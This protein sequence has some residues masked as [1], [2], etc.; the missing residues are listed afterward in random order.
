MSYKETIP[1][2]FDYLQ[3]EEYEVTLSAGT[4]NVFYGLLARE[5]SYEKDGCDTPDCK[6][7]VFSNI[8]REKDG[9]EILGRIVLN[10]TKIRSLKKCE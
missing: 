2:W 7:Y 4:H 5:W 9:K 8:K 1:G 6:G 3:P 10:Y